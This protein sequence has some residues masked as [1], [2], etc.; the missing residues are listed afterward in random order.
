[1]DGQ[2]LIVPPHTQH[3]SVRRL[4]GAHT[5][6]PVRVGASP[7]HTHTH[8]HTPSSLPNG[9]TCSTRRGLPFKCLP[10][11]GA[12]STYSSHR[13]AIHIDVSFVAHC[14]SGR[15]QPRSC[16]RTT[17]V[18]YMV[19]CSADIPPF[20]FSYARRMLVGAPCLSA[21]IGLPGPGT[22]VSGC[23]RQAPRQRGSYRFYYSSSGWSADR[24]PFLG[25]LRF[26]R[27]WYKVR[28]HIHAIA[29]SKASHLVALRD[30]VMTGVLTPGAVCSSS[31]RRSTYR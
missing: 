29:T 4:A 10:A 13:S 7:D 11:R 26:A 22:R 31:F 18:L 16:A 28:V 21:R 6:R 9:N 12:F 1:M 20:G 15:T 27:R 19:A 30:S 8:T 17:M 23:L 2:C 25:L 24:G 14:R 3:T 5:T